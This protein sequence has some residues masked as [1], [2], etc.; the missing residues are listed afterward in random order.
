VIGRRDKQAPFRAEHA[1]HL[2]EQAKPVLHVLEQLAGPHHRKLAISER[3]RVCALH[4]LQLRMV[5]PSPAQRLAGNIGTDRARSMGSKRR[6]ES[7]VAAAQ[8]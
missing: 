4:K 6:D 3:Q 8:I 1:S 7:T 2:L 5:K